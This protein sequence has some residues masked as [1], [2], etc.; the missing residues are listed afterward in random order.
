MSDITAS[1]QTP[2]EVRNVL[3]ESHG[4]S[5]TR[6]EGNLDLPQFFSLIYRMLK[7]DAPQIV[8]VPAYPRYL[9]PDTEEFRKT[10]DNPVE[11]FP[12]TI[13][14]KVIRREPGT[15]GGNKEPFGTGFKERTP[16]ERARTGM[17]DG[18]QVVVYGQNFDNEIKF[19]VWCLTNFEA[20]KYVNWFEQYLRTR[21]VWLRNQ[22]IGEILFQRRSEDATGLDNKLEYRSLIFFVRTE[23]LSV[24]DETVLKNLEISLG[25]RA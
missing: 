21:R 9:R 12:V 13:T 10:M 4:Q 15:M 25:I 8:F 2:E 18:S 14:H 1:L 6:A 19:E 23:E 3:A 5:N 17:R 11:K 7:I 22:G 24:E 16:H 20:E